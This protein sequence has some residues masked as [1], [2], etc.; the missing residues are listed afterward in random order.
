[1]HLI[2]YPHL[3]R[4]VDTSSEQNHPRSELVN[5]PTHEVAHPQGTPRSHQEGTDTHRRGTPQSKRRT[6]QVKP[7]KKLTME[8]IKFGEGL[9]R[10]S[11][12]PVEDTGQSLR[13]YDDLIAFVRSVT[14]FHHEGNEEEYKARQK[15]AQRLVEEKG[16]TAEELFALSLRGEF[17][18]NI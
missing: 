18:S 8:E 3:L 14:N 11:R 5:Q 10:R 2:R 7:N 15:E 12:Q 16:L 13:T 9:L 6:E 17:G 1:M 4:S